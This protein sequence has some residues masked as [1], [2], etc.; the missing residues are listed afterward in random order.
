MKLSRSNAFSNLKN[1][2]L[3]V[4]TKSMGMTKTDAASEFWLSFL[5][6]RL[7]FF[8]II[9]LINDNTKIKFSLLRQ[10]FVVCVHRYLY[11]S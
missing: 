4:E 6:N 9:T 10:L 11:L 2:I 5:I 8:K 1:A 3:E 7:L